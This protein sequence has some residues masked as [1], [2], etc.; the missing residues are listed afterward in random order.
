[1]HVSQTIITPGGVIGEL[2]VVDAEEMQDGGMQVVDVDFVLGGF[3]TELVGFAIRE[4]DHDHQ[5]KGDESHPGHRPGSP[6]FDDSPRTDEN[7][8]H[9]SRVGL[10][11]LATTTPTRRTTQPLSTQRPRPTKAVKSNC[12]SSIHLKQ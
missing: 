6:T 9:R 12:S 10:V 3:E 8:R 1:M 11:K 4:P 5:K 7:S 2:F